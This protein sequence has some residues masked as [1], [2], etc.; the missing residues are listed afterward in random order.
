MAVILLLVAMIPTID[1]R[2]FR[3]PDEQQA[4]MIRNELQGVLGDVLGHGHGIESARLTKIREGLAPIFR[5]LPKNQQGRISAPIMRYS[6]QRYFSQEYGWILKGFE[7]HAV[8]ANISDNSGVMQSKLPDYIR[9][10]L[11][12]KFAHSGFSLEDLAVMVAAVERLTFDEV[13]RGVELAF[14]LNSK[15]MTDA[16][17]LQSFLDV[18]TSYLITEMLEGTSNEFAQHEEDK[19]GILDLYPHWP[20]T[21]EFL[22]DLVHSEQFAKVPRLNPFIDHSVYHF[23]DATRIAQRI[24]EVFASWSNHECHEIKDPL[25]EMDIHKTGRVKLSQFYGKGQGSGWQYAE[26]SEYLRQLGAL[27]ESSTS[28]GPQVIIPNYVSGMSNCITSAPYYSI[29]CLNA[30]D[31]VFQ[32]LEA[33][34]PSSTATTAMVIKAVESMPDVASI[35]SGNVSA[36]LRSKLEEVAAIHNGK[37]PLHGRLLAQ[38]LHYVFPQDCPFPHVAGTVNPQTPMKFEESLGQDATT[39]TEEEVEQFLKSDSAKLGPSPEAGAAMWNLKEHILDSATPSDQASL[40]SSIRGVLRTIASLGLLA[41]LASLLWKHLL[42]QALSITSI[43]QAKKLE[44][45][46]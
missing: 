14:K 6:V 15:E 34:I 33:V 8:S 41:A 31:K 18:L 26:A 35:E 29:C 1:G 11:E 42:P 40:P 45:E 38:W 19:K 27:D 4:S 32:H 24:S 25:V 21:L 30:C 3:N 23:D 10:A 36:A 20:S 43:N 12:E 46:V 28:L 44:Y 2:S 39:V 5:S 22:K 13:I 17:D 37:V 16:L 7:P 9:T